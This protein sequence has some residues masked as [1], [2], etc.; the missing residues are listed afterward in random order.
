MTAVAVK[1][2]DGEKGERAKDIGLNRRRLHLLLKIHKNIAKHRSHKFLS[3]NNCFARV[4]ILEVD[5]TDEI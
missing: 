1:E 2:K 3:Q 5:V 4:A